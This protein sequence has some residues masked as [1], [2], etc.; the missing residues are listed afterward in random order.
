M[1][2]TPGARSSQ[3]L[4]Q[5]RRLGRPDPA[6]SR[7]PIIVQL[8]GQGLAGSVLIGLLLMKF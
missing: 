8:S 1:A 5:F 2:S 6:T 4:N 7:G 3:R